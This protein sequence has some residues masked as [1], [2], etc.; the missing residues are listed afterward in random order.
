MPDKFL[1]FSPISEGPIEAQSEIADPGYRTKFRAPLQVPG[2][3]LSAA[4]LPPADFVLSINSGVPCVAPLP[5]APPSPSASQSAALEKAAF[6]YV[7]SPPA[8]PALS[9]SYR[10]P[11]AV[12]KRATKFFVLRIGS[13]FEAVTIDRLKPHLGG[14]ASPVVPPRR[15]SPPGCC[16]Q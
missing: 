11:Y 8:A 15:G 10:G 7:R 6:V 14:P 2:Q 5:P 16:G 1:P 12:H 3:F 9:P 13:R 4:E